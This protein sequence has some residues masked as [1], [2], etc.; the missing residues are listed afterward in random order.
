MEPL[1]TPEEVAS[2]LGVAPSTVQRWRRLKQGP[3]FIRV[4]HR[5]VRYDRDTLE[6]WKQQ[7]TPRPLVALPPV[8]E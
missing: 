4:G 8:S 5:T 6:A 2:I 1:L 3:P 7:Q